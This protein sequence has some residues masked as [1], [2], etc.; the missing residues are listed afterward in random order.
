V[1]DPVAGTVTRSIPVV[2]PWQEP[3]RWQQP[4]PAL[5]VRGGDA[6]VTDPATSTVHRIDLA[7]GEIRAS[8]TLPDRPNELSG[9]DAH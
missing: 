8:V 3:P 4:R 2:E 1:I 5:F 6:Y 7:T 9:V